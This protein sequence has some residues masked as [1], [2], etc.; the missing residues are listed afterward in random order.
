MLYGEMI[1]RY[2]VVLFLKYYVHNKSCYYVVNIMYS[3]SSMLYYKMACFLIH[4]RL[5]YI[6]SYYHCKIRQHDDVV[7][8]TRV[9]RC[10]TTF[11]LCCIK[12]NTILLFIIYFV[13]Q[14]ILVIVSI[15]CY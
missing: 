15:K 2:Y 6:S 3:S 12:K 13:S 11:M 10:I 9:I 7:I 1:I 4:Y 8:M 5:Q 14:C